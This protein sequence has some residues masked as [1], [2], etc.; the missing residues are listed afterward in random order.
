[1][2]LN[3]VKML[4]CLNA[5]MRNSGFTLVEILV[6]ISIIILLSGIVL[7]NYRTGERQFAL[8]RSATKLASDIRRAQEMAMSTEECIHLTACPGGGVPAG[9]YG[10]YIDKSVTD[11]YKIYADDGT[12]VNKQYQYKSGEDIETISLEKGVYIKNLDPPSANFSINFRPPD[13]T[14]DIKDEIGAGKDN[15]TITIALEAEPSKTKT[16][17]VNKVGRIDID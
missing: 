7:V 13:P 5:K 16:I 9:G 8:Q 6:A 15:V 11:S 14:I 2:N 17:K 12:P 1:M 3:F 4:K 10:I